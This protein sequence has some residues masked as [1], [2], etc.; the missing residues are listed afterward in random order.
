[1]GADEIAR[2]LRRPWFRAYV[3]A[4]E[5]LAVA[6]SFGARRAD[7]FLTGRFAG[8]E[9]TLKAIRTGLGAGVTPRQVAIVRAG[10]GAPFVRLTGAAARHAT[11]LGVVDVAVSITHKNGLVV[12]AAVAVAEQESGHGRG[13]T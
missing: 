11:E 1:M 6:D 4:Q 9:A 8:K 12:A 2:L 13:R 10:D 3:Y 7:E 5:E